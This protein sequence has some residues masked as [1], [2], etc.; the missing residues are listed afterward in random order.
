MI[1]VVDASV[2]IKWFVEEEL[3]DEALA[4]LESEH[5]LH[6]PDLLFLEVANVA[7]KKALRGEIEG[8][9][10]Y[11]ITRATAENIVT[12][13]PATGLVH[14]VAK[15]VTGADPRRLRRRIHV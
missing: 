1:L 7:W 8:V 4:L 12:F 9:D 3:H 6:G 5:D 15:S 14:E 2:V 10:A 11:E 13:H